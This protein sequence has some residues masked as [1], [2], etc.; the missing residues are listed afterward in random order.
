MEWIWDSL[1]NDKVA[2]AIK[3]EINSNE[4]IPEISGIF[5]FRK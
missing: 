4:K 1:Q 5:T 2:V 3:F